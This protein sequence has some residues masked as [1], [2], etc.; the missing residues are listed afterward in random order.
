M[1]RHSRRRHRRTSR[2]SSTHSRR[3]RIGAASMT[4]SNPIVMIGSLAAGYFLAATPVNDA[5]DKVIPATVDKKL[6]A[7][8]EAGIGALLL[9]GK[10]KKTMLKSIAG[11]VLAGAGLKRLVDAMKAPAPTTTTTA[12][13][14]WKQVPVIGGGYKMVPVIGAPG[15]TVPN[16]AGMNGYNVPNNNSMSKIMGCTG[17]S[18]LVG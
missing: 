14:G 3:R 4:A 5:L 8:G 11:G 18:D 10:G 13:T 9:M 17:G 6:V 2:K 1:P 12:V 7:A 16:N 15:Y